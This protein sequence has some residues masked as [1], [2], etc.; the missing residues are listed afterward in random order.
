MLNAAP[1][2][3]IRGCPRVAAEEVQ[4]GLIPVAYGH[5]VDDLVV[6]DAQETR[7]R[8]WT[9]PDHVRTHDGHPGRTAGEVE[10]ERGRHQLAED[11][12]LDREVEQGDRPV[13]GGHA[14]RMLGQKVQQSADHGGDPALLVMN[15]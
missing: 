14:D 2:A 12:R 8:P 5:A 11:L 1:A 3:T 15:W 9:H 13:V 10:V 4:P 7:E 6:R